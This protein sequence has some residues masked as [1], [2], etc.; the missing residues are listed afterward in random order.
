MS[1]TSNDVRTVFDSSIRTTDHDESLSFDRVWQDVEESEKDKK[2][3]NDSMSGKD[4]CFNC[5]RVNTLIEDNNHGIIVCNKCGSVQDSLLDE[6]PEWNQYNNDDHCGV[7]KVRCGAPTSFFLPKSSMGTTI[8]GSSY[9]QIKKQ[10]LWLAMPH[11]E[12]SLNNALTDI[13][14]RCYQAG[15]KRNI[16]DD[17]QIFYKLIKDYKQA[18][19]ENKD[20]SNGFRGKKKQSI[21]AGCVYMACHK[22]KKPKSSKDIAQIFDLDVSDVTN[23]YRTCKDF[24]VLINKEDE[25]PNETFNIDTS[26]ACSLVMNYATKLKKIP[27]DCID[28][29]LTMTRNIRK[30]G[31][32]AEHTPPSIATASLYL[33]ICDK[34]LD[35]SKKDIANVSGMSDATIIKPLSKIIDYAKVIK[36]DEATEKLL[37]IL[38]IER[39]DRQ[40]K[41]LVDSE[42]PTKKE[43]RKS[44]SNKSTKK[45]SRKSTNKNDSRKS[46]NKNDSRKSTSKESTKK[47]SGKTTKKESK[48]TTK[49]IIK[50]D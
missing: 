47:D 24:M 5:E 37:D 43:S 8:S 4:F 22:R 14:N 2:Y 32:A 26:D 17:A 20:G 27:K 41:D 39:V 1:S 3:I 16:V 33:M 45:E 38:N 31:L 30:L 18:N 29:A 48:K 11:K 10:Q 50:I 49:R 44:T 34:G 21:K 42:K 12:R 15:I 23:G 36:S 13:K 46:T 28:L 25:F 6:T 19:S 9:S 35:I 7:S 40:Q